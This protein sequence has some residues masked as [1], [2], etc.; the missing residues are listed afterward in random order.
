M[1]SS[2]SDISSVDFENDTN[3][4]LALIFPL[5]YSYRIKEDFLE[6][7][8]AYFDGNFMP[9]SEIKLNI[10]NLGFTRGYGAY[11]CFRT[12]GRIPFHL[13]KHIARLK[14]TCENLY[15]EFPNEDFYKI[16]E[17]LL[18]KNPGTDIIVR[19]HVV[20]H[21]EKDSY[22]LSLL[23]STPEYHFATMPNPYFL[24]STLDNREN[25]FKSTSY[26][27]G[28]IATRKAKHL[29]F[30]DVL[31]IGEDN[32]VHELSRANIFAVKDGALYTS[33]SNCLKGI[34]RSAV[35]EI[36]RGQ[37]IP[38]YEK[39]FSL[40]FL[41]EVDEVFATASIRGLTPIAKIDDLEFSSHKT[42]DTLQNIFTSLSSSA[43]SH[44]KLHPLSSPC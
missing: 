17:T 21:P 24:K 18:E 40:D 8:V 2:K 42:C 16:T 1:V 14:N 33:V 30:N 7:L 37:G 43:D 28:I 36:A 27:A 22:Q 35:L 23:C 19:I 13:D 25:H 11:E 44:E 10:E 6:D 34:T 15:L 5:N 9:K 32:L 12:Y 41:S 29:G 39:D 38:T 4:L 3:S 31:F 26:S 20:D